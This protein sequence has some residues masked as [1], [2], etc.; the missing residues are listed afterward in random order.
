MRLPW[1]YELIVGD[2]QIKVTAEH[3]FYLPEKGW[4]KTKD[5]IEG[6]RLYTEDRKEYMIDEITKGYV[7]RTLSL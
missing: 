7:N 1:I 2:Q 6:D 5:L 4:I 3:P